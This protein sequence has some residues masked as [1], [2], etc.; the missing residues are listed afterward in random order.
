MFRTAHTVVDL[1]AGADADGRLLD[2]AWE[3][4]GLGAPLRPSA[5]LPGRR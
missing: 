3:R 2:A 1:A 5:P 4:T